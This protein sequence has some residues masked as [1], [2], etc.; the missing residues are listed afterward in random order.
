MRSALLKAIRETKSF[1]GAL[2]VGFKYASDYYEYTAVKKP[3][4]RVYV[5]KVILGHS[6]FGYEIFTAVGYGG[7]IDVKVASVPRD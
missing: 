3:R 7:N 5:A 4:D 6:V 1:K 2:N